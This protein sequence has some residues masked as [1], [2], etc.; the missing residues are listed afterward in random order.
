M[1]EEKQYIKLFDEEIAKLL[2]EQGGFSYMT[3]KINN[4]QCV[5]IFY[6]SKD[7]RDLLEAINISQYC[8]ECVFA[9]ED[10][11]CF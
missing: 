10:T 7:V 5:Y 2:E 1:K 4:G 8:N 9:E 3:E 6:N 11:L